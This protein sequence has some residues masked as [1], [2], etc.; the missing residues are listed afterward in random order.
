MKIG[1][2]WNSF[3]PPREGAEALRTA[4]IEATML[5]AEHPDAREVLS[6]LPT[7]GIVCENLHAPFD[8]IN[9]VWQEDEAGDVMLSRLCVALT[10]AADFDVPAVV[11]HLS[12]K[13]PMPAITPVGEERFARLVALG[14]HLGV[15][16]IF[17]NQRYLK[18]LA[19]AMERFPTA[20]FCWDTG[21]EHC[22][23]K[24]IHFMSLY[25]ER[26]A[27]LHVHDNR[28]IEDRDEHL[29]PFDGTIDFFDVARRIAE[30]RYEGSLMLE[31]FRTSRRNGEAIYAP[32]SPAAFYREAA[33]RARR[34][35]EMVESIRKTK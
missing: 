29:L 26:L 8:G 14:E 22:F 21:H 18:N 20:G 4:G 5:M 30:S 17:E 35:A 25:G 31:V 3:L 7:R 34:L 32:L 10:L 15:R 2:Q 23:T 9:A 28:C 1:V 24:D 19:W 13:T 11:V 12:S 27:A 16:V 33:D 6:I